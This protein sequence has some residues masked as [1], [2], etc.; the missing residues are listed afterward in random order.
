[1]LAAR[2]F[3]VRVDL[4]DFDQ[5]AP[6]VSFRDPFTWELL[7]FAQLPIGQ[8]VDDY[9]NVLRVVLDVHPLTKNP[10]LCMR[11]TR[12]YHE[13]PQHTGDA[14]ALYRGHLGVFTVLSTVWRTCV[15]RARPHMILKSL[16][17]PTLQWEAERVG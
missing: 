1:M 14:W 3:G 11:G 15:E 17:N 10:F 7:P 12:E 13:H 16:S 4:E 5:R 8:H 9:N 2:S 6:G